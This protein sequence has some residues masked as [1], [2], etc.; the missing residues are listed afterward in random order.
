MTEQS[1]PL[2]AD[3]AAGRVVVAVGPEEVQ[4]ALEFGVEEARRAGCGLH[5]VHVVHMVPTGPE[6]VMVT[7]VDLDKFGRETLDMAVER[8]RHLTRDEVPLSHELR[9]GSPAGTLVAASKDARMVVLEHRHLSRTSRIVNRTV[10]GGVAAYSRVPV[11]AVPSGWRR[12]QGRPVVVVGV[13]VPERARQVVGAAAAAA[14]ARGAVLRVVHTWR[15]PFTY[16]GL[17]LSSEEA[18]RWSDRSVAEIT[19]LLDGL[20]DLTRGLDVD[21]QVHHGRPADALLEAAADAE[22][23]VV[24]RH[25]PLLPLGSHV[26]PVTRAVLREATCPVLLPDPTPR[27]RA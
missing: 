15:M 6:A 3:P 27:H 9:R 8:A 5:L 2:P 21:V 10:A 19:T 23:L 12:P 22:L 20:G 16:E 18:R 4:S 11:V 14:R 1:G 25:D 17:E 7:T 24:G 26:G 13:D